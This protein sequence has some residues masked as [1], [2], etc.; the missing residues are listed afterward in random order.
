MFCYQ[1]LL[2]CHLSAKERMIKKRTV[3]IPT[4]P[5]KEVRKLLIPTAF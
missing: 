5:Y 1:K 4:V 3:A 2:Q